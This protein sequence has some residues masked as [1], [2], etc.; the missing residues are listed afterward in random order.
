MI[1]NQFIHL[2]TISLD[3][4][5]NFHFY[6]FQNHRAIYYSRVVK[7]S[8]NQ[9]NFC[10]EKSPNLK[11]Y[12]KTTN[13]ILIQFKIYSENTLNHIMFYS[14]NI[15]SSCITLNLYFFKLIY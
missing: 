9:Y 6:F 15:N 8:L 14:I 3:S 12:F 4:N 5:K 7:M 1:Y 10:F 2:F 13:S 11:K